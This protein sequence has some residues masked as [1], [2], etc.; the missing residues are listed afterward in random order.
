MTLIVWAILG[1]VMLAVVVWAFRD[2]QV[3]MGRPV[4]SEVRHDDL[5]ELNRR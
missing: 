5:D 4:K 2:A 1:L 3:R